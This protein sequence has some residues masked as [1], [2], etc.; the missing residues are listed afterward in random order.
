MST[1]ET[2]MYVQ[3]SVAV[4][5][6][7]MLDIKRVRRKA[8]ASPVTTPMRVRIMPWPALLV[9]NAVLSMIAVGALVVLWSMPSS[10]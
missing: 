7:N 1:S 8:A 10:S 4:T 2:P 3:G 6:Y 5:P 9:A